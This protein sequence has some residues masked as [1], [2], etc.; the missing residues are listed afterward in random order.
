MRAEDNIV[1]QLSFRNQIC[2]TQWLIEKFGLTAQDVR[3]NGNALIRDFFDV[4]TRYRFQ[5]LQWFITHF[6]LTIDDARTNDA[7]F[8]SVQTGRLSNV[9]WMFNY[10]RFTVEDVRANNNRVLRQCY[11]DN[12]LLILQWL[13]KQFDL[14]NEVRSCYDR[15]LQ[16]DLWR[17]RFTLIWTKRHFG[18]TE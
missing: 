14:R 3:A 13:T 12:N 15:Q 6:G 11:R 5:D 7:L 4:S 18:F 16:Q 1:I 2:V 9:Q 17:Q 8:F 10:F